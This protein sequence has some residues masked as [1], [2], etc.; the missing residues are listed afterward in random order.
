[1]L[2]MPGKMSR[3]RFVSCACGVAV[4][5]AAGGLIGRYTMRPVERDISSTGVS[6][7]TAVAREAAYYG[8]LPGSTNLRCEICF[9][10]CVVGEGSRGYCRSRQNTRG[11]YY[12]LVYG[13]PVAIH[14]DPIEKL[15]LRHVLPGT[16]T[17]CVGT[18]C[19][20]FDCLY[21][22][23]WNIARKSPEEVEAFPRSAE[24]V[25]EMALDNNVPTVCFTYNEPTV[26][27]EYVYDTLKLAHEKGLRTCFH[28][29]GSMRPEPLK[30]LLPNV[31]AVVADLKAFTR[32]SYERITSGEMSPVLEFLENVKKEDVWLEIVNLLVPTLNDDL[33]D[34]KQMC[35]WI[36]DTV[37]SDVPLHFSRFFPTYKLE[38]LSPTPVTLLEEAHRS[39]QESGLDYVYV[40]N[41]PSHQYGNTFCPRC[42]R[43]LIERKEF[44]IV[45]N[46]IEG[47]RCKF[48]GQKIPGIWGV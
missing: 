14:I 45:A 35:A 21:C 9:R 8:Q 3:R 17:L 2:L 16:D 19:C 11:R 6:N 44:V 15:P 30:A 46:Y 25:V 20:N 43:E 48:C 33:G 7:A 47:G 22:I 4:V 37:G 23:N 13:R 34:V 1:V 38:S 18:A 39:A 24:E 31:D 27:Y 41:V 26:A 32:E 28:S 5:A 10:R 29:N 40:N 42:G 12:S 36:R